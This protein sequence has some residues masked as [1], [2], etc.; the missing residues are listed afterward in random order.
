M[1]NERLYHKFIVNSGEIEIEPEQIRVG[2]K[3]KRDLPQLLELTQKIK[4]AKFP[5]MENKNICFNASVST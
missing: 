3:K 2:L 4:S 1:S 5:W